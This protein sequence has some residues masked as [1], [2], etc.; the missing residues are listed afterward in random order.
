MKVLLVIDMQNDFIGGALGTKEAVGIVPNVREKIRLARQEGTL[1]IFTRDTHADDYLQTQEGALLPVPHCI[2]GTDGWQLEASLD[3]A[4]SRIFDKP[5]FGSEALAAYLKTLPN[6]TEIEL[7]GVCTDIC[8]IT[9]ALL[10]KTALPE[11]PVSVDASACA[12]VSPGSH[13]NALR[14]MQMCQI[15]VTGVEKSGY[16]RRTFRNILQR[17]R[18]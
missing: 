9:N 16:F 18:E 11:V 6:I 10:V 13:A 5:C 14:A 8:V 3:A 1:V 15:K 4:D 7:C 12:G 2:K 17:F